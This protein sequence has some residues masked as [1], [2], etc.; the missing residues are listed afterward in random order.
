MNLPIFGFPSSVSTAIFDYPPH[1]PRRNNSFPNPN[2]YTVNTGAVDR[3]TDLAA[4]FAMFLLLS[5]S[6]LAQTMTID[7][8]STTRARVASEVYFALPPSAALTD[9][10]RRSTI[11][12]LAHSALER[13]CTRWLRDV[14]SSQRGG[15]GKVD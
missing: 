6:S 1:K 12:S 11:D 8:R 9:S 15:R 7:Q 5:L 13:R 4:A 2:V 10:S 14:A 3:G